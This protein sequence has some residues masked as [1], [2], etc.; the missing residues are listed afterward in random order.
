MFPLWEYAEQLPTAIPKGGRRAFRLSM[1][2]E[3]DDAGL[4]LFL[5]VVT[6]EKVGSERSRPGVSF[7]GAW[8][9]FDAMISERLL[10]PCGDF[11]HHLPEHRAYEVSFPVS[12][13]REGWNEVLLFAGAAALDVV[14]IELAVTNSR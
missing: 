12:L 4:S 9:K 13:I 7:N 14:S 2:E 3:P 6:K 8:P 11:T 10:F 5:Q 1:C